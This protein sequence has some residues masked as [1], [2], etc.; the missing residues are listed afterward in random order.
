MRPYLTALA[1]RLS[2]TGEVWNHSAGV[3]VEVQGALDSLR[4]FLQEASVGP[5]AARV[6]GVEFTHLSTK[7]EDGFQIRSSLQELSGACDLPVDVANCAECLQELFDPANRR[8]RYPFIAC[9]TCGPRWTILDRMPFDRDHTSMHPF[10]LCPDCAREYTNP[11]DRRYHAQSISCPNCGPKLMAKDRRGVLASDHDARLWSQELIRQGGIVAVQGVGGFHLVCDAL[12]SSAVKALRERKGRGDKP[13]ALLAS[14]IEMIRTYAHC[15]DDEASLLSGLE[16]PIVLLQSIPVKKCSI[17]ADAVAPGVRTLGFMLPSSALHELLIQDHPLVL[18][19]ANRSGEPLLIDHEGEANDI[20]LSLADGILGHD[21]RIQNRCDDTVMQFF[22]G[23]PTFIRRSRGFSP[24][25]ISVVSSGPI[26]LALGGEQ[27][28]A[29]ALA[30]GDRVYLGPHIGDMHCWSGLEALADSVSNLIRLWHVKPDLIACDAHPG[31]L[32][33]DWARN[34]SRENQIPLVPVIHHYAHVA[35]WQSDTEAFDEPALVVCFDGTGWGPDGTIWGGEFFLAHQDRIQRVAH[36]KPVPLPGGDRAIEHPA[37]MALAHL[38]SAGISWEEDLPPVESM[39]QS[40]RTTL[41]QQLEK[42][43]NSPAT[44]SMGRLFD[45]VAALI[46]VRQQCTYEAQAAIELETMT[47]RSSE[48]YEFPI[49]TNDDVMVLNPTVMMQQIVTDLRSRV[50]RAQIAGRFHLTIAHTILE[51]AQVMR[52]RENTHC[53][54][55]TG[56]VFQNRKLTELTI[57]LLTTSGFDVRQHRRIPC[58]DGGLSVGQALI[59]RQIAA[60]RNSG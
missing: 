13:F 46:G 10:R 14:S 3:V 9:S 45:A 53:I 28:T 43:L 5:K 41:K 12:D 25:S 37:R 59:A 51:I 49:E 60:R 52:G 15:S 31:F 2:L 32:S 54:G 6:R 44:S 47:E 20:L 27:K 17:L 38:W 29:L 24:E 16:R 7:E 18:T 42:N 22:A 23:D 26:V 33:H 40:F 1:N 8:Y 36:L 34:Y 39:D 55:L 35:S 19:S 21:R 4:C 48:R 30:L 50:S 57:D 56:G 58:N 11:A